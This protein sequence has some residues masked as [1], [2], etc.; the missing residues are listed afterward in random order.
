MGSLMDR[1]PHLR[2]LNV[3][4]RSAV[5]YGVS[6]VSGADISGPLLIIAGAGTGKTSTLAHRVAHLIVT[7]TLPERIL[8]LTFSSR[9]EMTS[10][11]QHILA[12][13]RGCVKGQSFE[14]VGEIAGPAPST[15]LVPACS[16]NTPTAFRTGSSMIRRT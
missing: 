10:Q 3:G 16:A 4:Q 9:A 6:D 7:S 5:E 1:P 8:L 11:A 12:A 15:R 2:D 14:P 13:A